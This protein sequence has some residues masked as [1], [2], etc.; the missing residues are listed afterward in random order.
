MLECNGSDYIPFF[1]T[2]D[3]RVICFATGF[4]LGCWNAIYTCM[5]AHIYMYIY[6]AVINITSLFFLLN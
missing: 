1:R 4:I 3:F 5:Y 6:M 2:V